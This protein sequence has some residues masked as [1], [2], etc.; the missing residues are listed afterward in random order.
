VRG[1]SIVNATVTGRAVWPGSIERR[2]SFSINPQI[3]DRYD[4]LLTT[5]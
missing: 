2:R 4:G 5:R 1:A 3:G